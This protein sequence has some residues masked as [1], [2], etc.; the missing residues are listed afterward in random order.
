MGSGVMVSSIGV[1][2]EDAEAS[3][4]VGLTF[5]AVSVFAIFCIFEFGRVP[6]GAI[7]VKTP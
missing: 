7:L 2:I 4:F 3:P 1:D 6:R 5:A